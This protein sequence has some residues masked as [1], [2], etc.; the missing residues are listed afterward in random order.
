MDDEEA[1]EASSRKG[2]FLS[3]RNL[4]LA[5]EYSLCKG[6]FLLKIRRKLP[7]RPKRGK[8]RF[9]GSLLLHD[10]EFMALLDTLT[11]KI[12]TK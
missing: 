1:K 2:I 10:I 5:K 7:I 4:P 9:L 8:S 3:Q 11:L 12:A 6:S